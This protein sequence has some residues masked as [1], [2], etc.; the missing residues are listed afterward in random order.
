MKRN[1]YSIIHVAKKQLGLDD[2]AYRAILYGAGLESSK[3]I[4]T[5]VHFNTVMAA[6]QKLGFKSTTRWN[7]KRPTVSG[8][9]GMITK[10]QEYYIKGLWA[11]ASRFK[12]ETSLRKIIKRIGKV[13][14]ISFLSKRSASAVILALHDICWKAGF[15]PDTK[16][17]IDVPF[18]KAGGARAANEIP[19]GVLS[20]FDGRNRVDQNRQ[21]LASNAGSAD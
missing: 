10:P 13:D 2:A 6:F 5:D 16:E 14:D 18:S 17:A 12:D 4:K 15:N 8:I 7:G 19:S 1:K 21:R 11:L 3:D 9:H 20:S